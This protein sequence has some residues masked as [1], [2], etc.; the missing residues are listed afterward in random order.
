MRVFAILV[1]A[2][3]AATASAQEVAPDCPER[4][5]DNTTAKK[6]A[7]EWFAKGSTLFEDGNHTWAL[8]AFMCSYQLYGHAATLY[9]AAQAAKFAGMK[10]EALELAQRSVTKDPF[11]KASEA[12]N[13]LIEELEK[14]LIEEEEKPTEEPP[15]AEP[16]PPV[17]EEPAPEPVDTPQEPSP[18]P[19]LK[20][21]GIIALAI[22]GAALVTGGVLQGI[23]GAMY[24][25]GQETDDPTVFVEKRDMVEKMQKAA[26]AS[27]VIGGVAA[28]GGVTLLLLDDNDEDSEP[29]VALKPSPGGLTLMGRF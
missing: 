14:E 3:S 22:G 19:D 23:T 25:D 4:P 6:L 11:G 13:K 24:K 8:G 29:S 10:R 5:P 21:P 18:A 26:I 20:T 17:Q 16:E 28:L 9:N 2:L 12:A 15:P 7:A 27:F 1:V